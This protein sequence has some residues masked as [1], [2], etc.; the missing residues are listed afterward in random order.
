MKTLPKWGRSTKQLISATLLILAGL[1]LYSFRSILIPIILVALFSYV[2]APMVGWLSRRL[3]IGRG[4]AVLLIYLVLLG[5]VATLPAVTIPVIVDEVESLIENLDAI[6]NRAITWV[7]GLD[8]I[9]LK[10]LGYTISLP[11][12]I[13]PTFSFDLDRAMGLLES[14]ISPL[15]GGAFSVVKTVA[16]GVGWLVFMAVTAFYLLR[17]AERIGP[18]VIRRPE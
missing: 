18:R 10:V 7:E 6:T 8:E 5:A 1:L 4:W 3:H 11:E 14:A 12:I 2:V 17:D 16:S 9:E 15:A 13:S